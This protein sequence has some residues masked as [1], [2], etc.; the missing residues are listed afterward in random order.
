[1]VN[2]K[3]FRI[4]NYVCA[5]LV[6]ELADKKFVFIGD[7]MIHQGQYDPYL[8]M[9]IQLSETKKIYDWVINKDTNLSFAKSYGEDT[10]QWIGKTGTL[11]I[12]INKKGMEQVVGVAL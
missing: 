4:P 3:D 5:A 10:T 2:A 6:K 7:A 11:M 9:K 1:M 8:K 12:V